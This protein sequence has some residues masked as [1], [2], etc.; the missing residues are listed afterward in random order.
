MNKRFFWMISMLVIAAMTACS[1]DDDSIDDSSSSNDNNAATTSTAEDVLSKVT[2]NGDITTFNVDINKASLS[3][4]LSVDENDDDYIENTS[5]ASTIIVTFSTS[6]AATVEGDD[7]G[8][9]KINGNDVI[10]TNE[11]GKVIKYVLTGT[12][13]DGFFKLYSTKKQATVC[14]FLLIIHREKQIV[15]WLIEKNGYLSANLYKVRGFFRI[16]VP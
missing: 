16:F 14:F 7:S 10:A 12:T 1:S 8:I 9:I 13:N 11:T 5:F 2:S 15:L 3:E 6:G 4:T